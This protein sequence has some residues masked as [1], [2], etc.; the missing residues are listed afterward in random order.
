M[1]PKVLYG[2][3]RKVSEIAGL[4]VL[5]LLLSGLTAAQDQP[6]WRDDPLFQR[7]SASL[8]SVAAID[9]HTHL[10]GLGAMKFDPREAAQG[11][12]LLR[13]THPW[14]P[15]MIKARFGVTV[16]PHNWPLTDKSIANARAGMVKELGEHGYWISH[17]NYTNTEVALVNSNIRQGTDGQRL[18][19]VP[20][21]SILLY[22][23]PADHLMARSPR[24]R[25]DIT[26]LQRDL[27]GVLKEANLA[28]VPTDLGAYIDFVDQT[29]HRWQQQ[30]AVAVKFIDAYLR[31]LHIAEISQIQAARLYADGQKRPLPRDEYVALQ[32]FV[33]RHILLEAGKLHLVVHIH[34]SLGIP[35]FMRTYDSDV[36]NLDDVLTDPQFFATPIVLIHGGLPWNEIA[37]YQALKP[38]VW[39]DISTMAFLYPVPAFADR[40]RAYLVL[41]PEKVLYG[42]DAAPY[43]SVVGGADVLHIMLSRATRD[44]LYLALAGLVRDSVINE[45][46]AVEI[47]RG[48]LRENALRLYGWK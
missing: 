6:R 7:L 33:W 5:T 19:W 9:T 48:V 26:S 43:P 39:I 35:P 32:D 41:A 46:E 45:A 15:A 20:T 1:S 11:P 24:H 10:L 12:V 47:G 2:F 4:L 3:H 18:R 37:A 40:L 30:G 21:A 16:D 27:Q 23:L 29:L 31:T 28:A 14:L 36:S 8:D 44:A 25:D 22:P 13:S 42:T 34:S 38:N 17:L